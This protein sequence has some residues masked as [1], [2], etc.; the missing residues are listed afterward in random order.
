[1]SLSKLRF[2]SPWMQEALARSR[3]LRG[4]AARTASGCGAGTRSTARCTS[5]P[6][7]HLPG[8][9][10]NAK[11]DRVAMHSSVETRY[12]FLDEDVF[13]V[14]GAAA[15]ALEAAR[16]ARQVPAAAAGRALAAD[17]RSPGGARRCSGAV[18]QLPP[19][20]GAAVRRPAAQRGIAAQDRLLRRRGGAALAAGVPAAA[21][22][23]RCSA[24][25]SRWAWSAWWRRSCGITRSSTASLADLPSRP[26]PRPAERASGE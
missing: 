16:L 4:P 11:G 8:L 18:R 9:L 3:A 6:A 7:C 14:P 5:A 17:G 1:M 23:R 22:R 20:A 26:V 21:G 10:L 25:R 24:R 13:D 15:S 2:F 12:P 19:R